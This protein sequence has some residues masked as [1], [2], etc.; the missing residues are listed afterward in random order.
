[1]KFLQGQEIEQFLREFG[2]ELAKKFHEPVRVM[3]IGGAYMILTQHNRRTTKDVDIFPLNIPVSTQA[4]EE[5]K[6]FQAAVRAV[7]RRHGI[8]KDWLNDV[9]FSML[10]G[11]GPEPQLTLWQTFGMLEIYLPPEDFI[12][13]LKLF[14]YRDKDLSDIRALL[15]ALQV[16]TRE[17]AQAIADKYIYQRWQQEYKLYEALDDLF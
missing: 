6:N 13:A 17:H 7:A 9:A 16:T 4:S 2:D 11:L 1:M 8:P 3:L 14:A 10:G 5:T 12:L 15:E